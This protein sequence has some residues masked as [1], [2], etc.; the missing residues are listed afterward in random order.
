MDKPNFN[1]LKNAQKRKSWIQ[2]MYPDFFE[3]IEEYYWQYDF[4]EA[5][6]LACN[7]LSNPPSCPVCGKTLK[8]RNNGYPTYCSSKCVG[9]G[10]KEKAAATNLEKYGTKSFLTTN[11]CKQ[12][13]KDTN[14]KK[15]GVEHHF[16]SK[17]VQYGI[18][19]TILKKYGVDNALKL[20]SAKQALKVAN[21]KKYGVEHHFNSKEVQRKIHEKKKANH[22]NSTPYLLGYTEDGLMICKCPHPDS[23]TKCKEKQFEIG[24]TNYHNRIN[25]KCEICTI[26]H[27]INDNE[28]WPEKELRDYIQS[29]GFD[30][31]KNTDILKGRELDIYIPQKKI[32]I[33]FNGCYWHSTKH[34]QPSYHYQ[35]WKDCF[36]AGIQLITIWEDWWINYKEKC[37]NLIRSKLGVYKERI[38]ARK[39]TVK[40]IPV[41]DSRAFCNKY[42]IQ[43]ASP[44]S[45]HIGLFHGEELV[46]VMTFAKQ[47]QG[48]GKAKIKP[49]ELVRYCS[50]ESHV[51]GGAGKLFKF[52]L[53]KYHPDRVVSYSSNDISI[54]GVYKALGFQLTKQ[55]K[56]SYWYI[57]YDMKRHHRYSF[58]KFN[59]KKMGFDTEHLTES[60]I[61]DSL[62]YLK[63]YDSGTMTWKFRALT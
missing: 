26:L 35:K 2:R 29:L 44:A 34:K 36:D 17:E 39:C 16:N 47:R 49:W 23:C 1:E 8:Y 52:F 58:N 60:Q 56:S 40:D 53:R 33:E 5:L 55:N 28:S 20:E 31:E 24:N 37:K 3:F 7:N 15:Y 27:P 12:A 18:K 25:C 51:I 61:M 4:L 45:I 32:A 42:H 19:K 50:G 21:L 38:Y 9:I 10:T 59:L 63:I 11:K 57:G 43:G 54:G 46:S 48:I 22:I 13:L 30:C 6:Y 62:P 41:N 14:L